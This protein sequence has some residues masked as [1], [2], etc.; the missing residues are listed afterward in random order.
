MNGLSSKHCISTQ[1]NTQKSSGDFFRF[2]F[3]SGQTLNWKFHFCSELEMVTTFKLN[4]VAD[5]WA[6]N[7]IGH[8]PN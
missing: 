4:T 7:I 5:K 1:Q 6:T 3:P 8:C 2:P